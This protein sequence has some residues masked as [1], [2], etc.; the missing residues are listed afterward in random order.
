[1]SQNAK[2]AKFLKTGK[3]LSAAQAK[4]QYGVQNLRA[5]IFDLRQDG[6]KI[7]TVTLK[8]GATAYAM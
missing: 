6:L 3:K 8:S 2:I 4:S 1:M 5:R 7:E